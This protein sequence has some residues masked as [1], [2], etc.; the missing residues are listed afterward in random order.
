VQGLRGA[1]RGGS[2]EEGGPVSAV[3]LAEPLT[4]EWLE[5]RRGGIGASEIA[6]VMG[7]SPWESPFSLYWRKVNGWEIEQTPEMA[8]GQLLEP[9]IAEW[10]RGGALEDGMDCAPEP[11]GLLAHPD[12]PWQLATP[13]RLVHG[14]TDPDDARF[15]NGLAWD[16]CA[17]L[18]LKWVAHSWDGW[19]EP[20]SD[21]IPVHYRAQVQW[22]CDVVG[23]DDWYVAAL[24]PGGFREYHGQ[25]DEVD[26]ILMR[27]HGRRFMDRLAAADP[28]R[29]DGHAATIGTLKRLHPSV[30]DRDIEVDVDFAEG[31]RRARAIRARADALV[32]RYEARARAMLG[33][34]RRLVCAGR[35]VVSR[36][37]KTRT[38]DSAELMAID[39]AWPTIDRLNPG[40]ARSYVAD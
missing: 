26:L 36:S 21:D 27:E 17:V 15:A 31:Y 14:P 23:V 25:R 34:A 7:I 39:D 30:D 12:R 29:L 8:T 28:P 5:Q 16:L 24:G 4:P 40:R 1:R 9:V 3:A 10:W 33:D 19:G 20:G 11:P 37:V 35:L 13:D 18:E 32:T 6:A 2:E 22:Q 38:E